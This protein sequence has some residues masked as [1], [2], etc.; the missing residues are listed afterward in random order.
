M[1]NIDVF[2]QYNLLIH[3][4]YTEHNKSSIDEVLNVPPNSL[5]YSST[6]LVSLKSLQF[7]K[8]IKTSIGGHN[9]NAD[10]SITNHQLTTIEQ[11]LAISGR[12]L[13]DRY[14]GYYIEYRHRNHLYNQA[15][16]LRSVYAY[17]AAV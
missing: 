4:N 15:A 7:V 9:N 11:Q 12:Q 1:Q 14:L 10:Y 5:I 17:R 2:L 16:V 6:A 13:L 8:C 3:R